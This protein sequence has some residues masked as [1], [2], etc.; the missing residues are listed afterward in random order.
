MSERPLGQIPIEG[1]CAP[2]FEP[3]RRAFVENF[4]RHGELGA[5]V[6]VVVR[7]EV[8]VDLGGGWSDRACRIPWRRDSL[9]NFFSVGKALA[10]LCAA[11]LVAGGSMGPEDPVC[12]HWPEFEAAGKERVTVAELLSHQAGLPALRRRLAPGAMLDHARMAAALAQERPWW[13]PGSA[14][15]Y[16][17]HTFGFLVGE[18]FRRV[19]GRSLGTA[20]REDVA[21]PLGADVHIGLP[22]A[23][24]ARVTDF[25]WPGHA[26]AE[27][28]PAGLDD[29]ELMEYNTY[30]NPSGLSGAGCVNTPQWRSAEIP[31][32]N[33]HGTARGVARVYEA[34]ASGGEVDG[35]AIV[36]R[37][38][39]EL[40]TR[41]RSSGVDLVL[42]RP[43]RFGLGFQL[44]Q[45]ERPL[46]PSPRAFGHFGAG[47]ALGF[48]DPDA[49]VAFGYVINTMGPRWQNPRN[50]GLIDALYASLDP[51]R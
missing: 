45:P 7:G 26:P 29:G 19:D 50:R 27:A 37:P 38:T 42:H 25:L 34:L 47:G 21:A 51:T 16:H 32:T 22:E 36:D 13:P 24:H 17:T 14:H 28:E 23:L 39:L 1:T 10:A 43:S 6:C 9:V 11:R 12:R 35:V 20:L 31:S 15:G 3:L 30:F 46:G 8:V 48:C 5:S 41:E 18:L 33:G 49:G 2:G 40:F 44:T 4:T